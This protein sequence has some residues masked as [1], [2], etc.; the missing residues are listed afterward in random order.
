MISRADGESLCA[1][2]TIRTSDTRFRSPGRAVT[3]AVASGARGVR[4]ELIA[5]DCAVGG[6]QGVTYQRALH[7]PEGKDAERSR[8]LEVCLSERDTTLSTSRIAPADRKQWCLT[9]TDD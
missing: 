5:A 8:Q 6:H 1:P 3:C 9:R 7:G 2:E 4:K